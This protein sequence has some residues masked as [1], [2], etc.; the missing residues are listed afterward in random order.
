MAEIESAMENLNRI[1]SEI[2]QAMYQQESKAEGADGTQ[3][4]DNPSG[5]G[6]DDVTDV[7]YEEVK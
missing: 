5:G 7:D 1:F 4:Q 2:G 3:N 6:S